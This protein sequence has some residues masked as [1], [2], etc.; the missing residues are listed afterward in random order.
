[1]KVAIVGIGIHPFGRYAGRQ[2]PRT[3]GARRPGRRW[4]TRAW[5]GRTCSSPSAAAY[6]RRQ[7]PDYAGVR[8]RPDRRPVHQR[9]GT[10]A[11]PAGSALHRWPPA[12]SCR[13]RTTSAW[14]W[15]ST[16]TRRAP[17]T[18]TPRSHG[19]GDWYGETGLMLTTQFFAM[20]IQRYMHDCTASATDTLAA[21][22]A[23]AFRN[24]ALQPE[25]VAPRAALTEDE[26]LGVADGEPPADPVHVLLAR[27]GCGGARPGRGGPGPRVHGPAGLPRAAG[28]ALPPVRDSFEVFSPWLSPEADAGPTVERPRPP[29]RPPVSAPEDVDVAQ[30]QDTESGRRDHAHGRDRPVQGRRA[31]GADRARRHR[32]RRRAADQHRRRA[33]WPTASRSARRGCGRSTRTSC[34]CAAPPAR[35]RSRAP[36]RSGSR[37]VYGAPG[38]SACTVLT[39]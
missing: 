36:R 25:R 21:V 10:G 33:A 26:I 24:G 12:R 2:R 16:S 32:D 4:P 13:A 11:P 14:S 27:R 34:S 29:S 5:R 23:K 19:L 39:R 30:I 31:G 35:G 6:A 22:A 20:K 8:P 17:S 28:V 7:T 38:I 1:M 15:G 18:P 9:R 37:H 3:G